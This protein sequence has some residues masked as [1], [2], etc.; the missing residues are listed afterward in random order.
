MC[1]SFKKRERS[2]TMA[3]LSGLTP[4]RFP[5]VETPRR[6]H[7]QMGGWDGMNQDLQTPSL[8]PPGSLRRRGLA[9]RASPAS[10]HL[11]G[12]SPKGSPLSS[13]SPPCP[14]PAPGCP[15]TG[16]FVLRLGGEDVILAHSIYIFYLYYLNVFFFFPIIY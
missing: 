8:L 5:P 10:T 15:L 1:P 14:H 7:K 3:L 9:T 13:P 16:G 4:A 12:G 2:L 6:S 11:A